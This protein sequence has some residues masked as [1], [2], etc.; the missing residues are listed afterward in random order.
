VAWKW[1]AGEYPPRIGSS[2]SKS[3]PLEAFA[4]R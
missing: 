1:K 4:E 2:M 3:S